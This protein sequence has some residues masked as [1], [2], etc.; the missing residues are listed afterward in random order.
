MC[1]GIA[2]RGDNEKIISISHLENNKIEHHVLFKIIL[3]TSEILQACAIA[4]FGNCG[5][6]ES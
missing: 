3:N 5:F 6:L 2:S 1:R 4:P